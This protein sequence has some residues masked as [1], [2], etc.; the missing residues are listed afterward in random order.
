MNFENY[1]GD[2]RDRTELSYRGIRAAGNKYWQKYSEPNNFWDYIRL[3]KY[4][5]QSM[6]PQ[7]RKLVPARA[8]ADIGLLVEPNIFERPK[9]IMGKDPSAVQANYRGK[10]GSV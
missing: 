6:Y 7:L 2:P 10:I 9:V 5:D 8:K 4:Y 3:L 1:I